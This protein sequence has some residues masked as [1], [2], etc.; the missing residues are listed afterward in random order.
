[1]YTV[2]PNWIIRFLE[3]HTKFIYC[4]TVFPCSL[5]IWQIKNIHAADP[6][7][8]NPNRWSPIISSTYWL[9]VDK[10]WRI[11]LCRQYYTFIMNTFYH[12]SNNTF[13]NRLLSL[14][15]ISPLFQGRL[16]GSEC[17]EQFLDLI[18]YAKILI[19]SRNLYFLNFWTVIWTSNTQG[20][21]TNGLTAWHPQPNAHS[22]TD[23]SDSSTYSKYCGN[24]Q[25]D[26]PS[27]VLPH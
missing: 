12:P 23:R 18:S 10:E 13:N 1:M 22:I 5:N 3:V 14:Q 4:R 25:T 9:N 6:L 11:K 21:D 26:R 16:I 2:P 27:H 19:I 20:T 24:Q 15:S 17:T 8:Q 7:H